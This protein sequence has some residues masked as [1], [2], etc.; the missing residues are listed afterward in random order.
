METTKLAKESGIALIVLLPILYCAYLWNS[1][2]AVIPIH[3]DLLGK[4]NGYGTK[5]NVIAMI[6]MLNILPYALMIYMQK[7]KSKNLNIGDNTFFNLR[8]LEALFFAIM[9]FG[10]ITA[11]IKGQ[12]SISFLFIS[13]PLFIAG[14]GNYMGQFRPNYIFG[15]RTPWTLKSDLNWKKT[16]QFTG[17]VWFFTGILFSIIFLLTP[18]QLASYV[19][20]IF[21]AILILAAYLYSY[22]LHRHYLNSQDEALIEKYHESEQNQIQYKNSDPWFGPF[23]FDKDDKRIMVP[24]KMA[25]FG[26]TL[27]F[28]NPY[29]YILLIGVIGSLIAFNYLL[30]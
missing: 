13:F 19:F 30:K 18:V 17:K 15:I 8:I 4:P 11:G 5:F 20:C 16:H 26:W 6:L 12:F 1:L 10:A 3:F 29:S 2:P 24:K 27:N 9:S 28:G 25:G 21:L 22:A 14:I 23:Y 7:T